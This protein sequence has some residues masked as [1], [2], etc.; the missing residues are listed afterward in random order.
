MGV[1]NLQTEKE[2]M[3]EIRAA[4]KA[5]AAVTPVVPVSTTPVAPVA[6]PATPVKAKKESLIAKIEREMME[7]LH[8]AEGET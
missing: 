3:D 1:F 5:Q 7:V 6:A 8:K 4:E 2:R